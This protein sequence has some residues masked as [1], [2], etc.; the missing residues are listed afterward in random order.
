M[1]WPAVAIM[2]VAV[3]TGF[4][5]VARSRVA[6]DVPSVAQAPTATVAPAAQAPQ[7]PAVPVQQTPRPD[8]VGTP[9]PP[10][11]TPTSKAPARPAAPR[12]SMP[13]DEARA[14]RL[15]DETR[16]E[17]GSDTSR[18]S[19]L[20]KER[21][22]RL[23]PQAIVEFA[24]VRR[25]LDRRAY[26]WTLWAAA[27]VV[28]DGCS[29][30]CFRDFR[31]Y[32]IS[33]G[34]GPYE[35]ALRNPDSLASVAQDAENGDWENADDVAPDAYSSVTGSDFPLEYGDLSGS[36]RGRPVPSADLPRRFP[37]LNARFRG[38]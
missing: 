21:L 13:P 26:T 8:A 7:P 25:R 15:I 16:R 32:V 33:L 11:R 4:V 31:A 37:R 22:T 9:R 20:L 14:W 29:D 3:V 34:H 6:S 18:E 30:D 19:E 23:S 2:V 24:H 17:A 35:R 12:P 28:E 27:S 5:L 10:A 38:R 36:P 1:K